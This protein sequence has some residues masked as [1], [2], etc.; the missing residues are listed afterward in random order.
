[1]SRG[2]EIGE[3]ADDVLE[4]VAVAAQATWGVPAWLADEARVV[5]ARHFHVGLAQTRDVPPRRLEAYFWGVV[6]RRAFRGGA[7]TR[8]LRQRFVDASLAA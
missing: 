7:A 4:K 3:N 8:D 1:M 6:R 2:S 5:T